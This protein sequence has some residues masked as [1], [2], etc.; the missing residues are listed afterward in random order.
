MDERMKRI[1]CLFLFISYISL[2]LP[3]S[4]VAE[5]DSPS[6]L[7]DWIG[8]QVLG[9]FYCEPGT[10]ASEQCSKIPKFKNV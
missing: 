10:E 6:Q 5:A 2:F 3:G 8:R 4:V 1:V 9:T 7:V